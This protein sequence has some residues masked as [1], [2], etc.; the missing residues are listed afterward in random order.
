MPAAV[1]VTS[2]SA[3][4]P[5]TSRLRVANRERRRP[6]NSPAWSFSSGTA[7]VLRVSPRRAEAEQ[8]RAQQ[9]QADGGH[10]D[11]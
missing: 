9:A 1:S 4:W 6:V 7:S 11:R 2:D 8:Q 10:H 5:M 3:S